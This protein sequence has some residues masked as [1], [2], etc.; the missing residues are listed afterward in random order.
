MM[1]ALKY[2]EVDPYSLA[3]PTGIDLCQGGAKSQRR[4][5]DVDKARDLW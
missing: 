3:Q 5:S 1:V 2:F 4:N